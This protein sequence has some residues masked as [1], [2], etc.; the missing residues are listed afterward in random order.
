MKRILSLC[1][2][3]TLLAAIFSSCSYSG[4]ESNSSDIQL[5]TDNATNYLT[6]SIRGGGSDAE[7]I[8]SEYKYKSAYFNGTITGVSGYTYN[9]VTITVSCKYSCQNSSGKTET[10]TLSDTTSLNVGGNGSVSAE[11]TTDHLTGYSG[12]HYC[13]SVECNGYVITSISGTVTK[14]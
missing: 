7:Y 14:N 10:F 1:V 6:F 5:T 12:Y 11:D 13:T 9:D 4:T 2:I 3:L 8:F